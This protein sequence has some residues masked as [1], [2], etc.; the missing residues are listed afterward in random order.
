MVY[1]WDPEKEEW[2]NENRNLSFLH[3]LYHSDRG[4]LL[5]VR[6]HTNKEKYPHQKVLIVK[7]N[8]YVYAVPFVEDGETWFLKTIIP[9]RKETKRYLK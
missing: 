7:M 4:D 2:L 5:D 3:V 8:D 6:E 1:D 9:S